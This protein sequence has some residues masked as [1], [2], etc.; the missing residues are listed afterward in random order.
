MDLRFYNGGNNGEVLNPGSTV[1][2]K[3]EF[4][5][6]DVVIPAEDGVHLIITQTGEDYIPS[7]I[8]TLPVSIS[9]DSNSILGLSTIT[10]TCDDFFL[11]PMHEIYADCT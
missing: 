10:R 1:I 9:I 6:M 7:P 2:A 5:G 11:P 3:M 4:F 8:S